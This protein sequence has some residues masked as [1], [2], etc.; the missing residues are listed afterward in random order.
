MYTSWSIG[1]FEIDV[2]CLFRTL[3][4]LTE[5]INQMKSEMAK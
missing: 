1:Y 3:D 4:T 5:L 2:E